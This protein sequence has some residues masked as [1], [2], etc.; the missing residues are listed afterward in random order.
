MEH[1]HPHPT[2][3]T[4]DTLKAA[5]A[6]QKTGFTGAQ[7]KAVTQTVV[8]AQDNLASKADIR[9][10]RA[11]IMAEFKEQRAEMANLRA[12]NKRVLDA[13]EAHIKVLRADNTRLEETLQAEMKSLREGISTLRWLTS[14]ALG[15]VISLALGIAGISIALA[16]IFSS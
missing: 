15:G 9:A 16:R 6:L 14:L 13:F 7:A 8:A 12:D 3:P 1:E 2:G 10:L 11:E 4:F 5:E